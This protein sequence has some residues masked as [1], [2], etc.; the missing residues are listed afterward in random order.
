MTALPAVHLRHVRKV[1]PGPTPV[2]ALDDV[3]LRVERGTLTV[4]AG[5][6]GSGKTTLLTVA[7]GLEHP[8]TGEVQVCGIDLRALDERRLSAFRRARLGFVF[9]DFRL[10]D[11]LTATENVALALELR[12]MRRAAAR[13]EARSMLRRLGL[14]DRGDHRPVKLSGGEKQRVALARALVGNPDLVLADEPTANLDGE[15]GRE[16]VTLLRAATRENGTTVLLVSHD[17][18]VRSL[19]D[20][21]VHLLDGR[22]TTPSAE[23]EAA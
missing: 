2:R 19:A 10:I 3:T 17:A 11:V 5:P 12:G 1:F 16:I 4:V 14:A 21:M 18:R 6:S 20:R 9:Q 8:T 15:T 22:L 7:G 13:A 23:E